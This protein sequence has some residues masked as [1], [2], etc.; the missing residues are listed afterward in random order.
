M[1]S[2]I[3]FKRDGQVVPGATVGVSKI[4]IGL[5]NVDNTSDVAKPISA[6][7]QMALDDLRDLI[8]TGGGGGDGVD[9]F[10]VETDSGYPVRP[11][12]KPVV[13]VGVTPPDALALPGD[14]WLA[15]ETGLDAA[16]VVKSINGMTG[17]VLLEA[18]VGPKGDKG[19]TGATGAAGATGPIGPQGPIGPT[20]P[21]GP[22]G[23]KGD[24]GTQGIQGV[25]GAAGQGVPTGGAAGRVLAKTSAT[26][27]ATAWV[28][29][30][31]L[32]GQTG[33][34]YKMVAGVLRNT[35]GTWSLINDSGHT[36]M[37]AGAITVTKDF[38]TVD[39]TAIGATRVVS[40]IA[41]PDET[42]AQ[43]GFTVGASVGLTKASIG[44]SMNARYADYVYYSGPTNGWISTNGVFT[45]TF[46]NTIGQ[47]SLIHEPFPVPDTATPF[48]DFNVSGRGDTLASADGANKGELRL[49]FHTYGGTLLTAPATTMKV[50]ASHGMSG[51]V[52]PRGVTNELYPNSNIWFL[53]I[54]EV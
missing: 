34:N 43:K 30:A 41:G 20:G 11:D 45:P 37:N 35:A 21:T 39:Y 14:V 6:A 25:Q 17:D 27:Y 46:N 3:F 13:F 49:R 7:T 52:D 53:G 32:F 12:S 9:R 10:L 26:N 5:G 29:M 54:F 28:E 50:F 2:G 19:D 44:M 4:S 48:W 51:P 15:N 36:P 31:N 47:L 16:N 42:L 18:G 8:G 22:T 40:F 23:P 33:K 1:A 38:V 24:T